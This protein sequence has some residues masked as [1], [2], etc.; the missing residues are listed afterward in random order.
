[1]KQI[2]KIVGDLLKWILRSKGIY[3]TDEFSHVSYSQF[4]EDMVLKKI[5]QDKP[6]GFYVD[7]GAFHPKYYSNTY[8]LY[9]KGWKGINIDATPGSMEAFKRIRP[10]DCNLEMPIGSRKQTLTYYMFEEPAF[11]GFSVANPKQV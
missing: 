10:R 3:T 4:G 2:N 8:L 9:L 6:D 11:N 7:V 1:M 5:F